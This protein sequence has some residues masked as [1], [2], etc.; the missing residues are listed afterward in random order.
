MTDRKKFEEKGLP[1]IENWEKSLDGD[2]IAINAD[3][4]VEQRKFSINLIVR[5]CAIIMMYIC[6]V[7]HC[8]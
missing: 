8:S 1:P 7:T 2:K 4:L 6:H 5:T 3:K